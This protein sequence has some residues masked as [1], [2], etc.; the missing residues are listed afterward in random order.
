MHIGFAKAPLTVYEVGAGDVFTCKS[1]RLWDAPDNAVVLIEPNPILYAS[2]L[3]QTAR[4]FPN[5]RIHNVAISDTN[6]LGR[7]VLAGVLSYL[8]EVPSPINTIFRGKLTPMLEGYEV[9]VNLMT[10]DRFDPGN[11]DL[12]YLGMEGSEYTVFATMVSRP[13]IIVLNNHFANDYGYAFPRFEVV[14]QWCE[15]N[16]YAIVPGIPDLTL[17]RVASTRDGT[18]VQHP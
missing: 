4:A 12:L 6:R 14:Q 13:H 17:V 7:L 2:L 16:E 15:A 3:K 8:P 18:L 11:I 5:V 1:R 10:F 9:P